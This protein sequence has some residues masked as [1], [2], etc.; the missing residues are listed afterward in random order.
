MGPPTRPSLQPHLTLLSPNLQEMSVVP[1]VMWIAHLLGVL[2]VSP[3]TSDAG[4]ATTMMVGSS[5]LGS[6]GVDPPSKRALPWS[7]LLMS[8]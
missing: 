1:L 3:S 7:F 4:V 2:Q 6:G 8:S 5:S